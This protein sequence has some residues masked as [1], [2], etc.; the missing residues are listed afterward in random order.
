MKNKPPRN[1]WPD[2]KY[3][4]KGRISKDNIKRPQLEIEL[5]AELNKPEKN[6][7]AEKIASLI[8]MYLLAVFFFSR[9]GTHLDWELIIICENLEE[10][11]KYNWSK[12]VLDFLKDDIYLGM[13]LTS[14]TC[15]DA[16]SS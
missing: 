2:S 5:S 12:M 9:S 4:E 10:I 11:N 1:K 14:T 8:L 3:F 7:D 6:Q 13:S 16:N 15:H